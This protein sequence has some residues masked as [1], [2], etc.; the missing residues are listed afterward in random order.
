MWTHYC[1]AE[2]GWLTVED[3]AV[4]NWC[5]ASATTQ[6]RAL[7]GRARVLAPAAGAAARSSRPT[8]NTQPRGPKK[9]S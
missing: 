2:H 1:T 9:R 3:G 6:S 5:D 4:C 8:A 7:R